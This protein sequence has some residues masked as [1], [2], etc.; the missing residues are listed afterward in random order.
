MNKN[1]LRSK[2]AYANDTYK[3]LGLFLKIS[4]QCVCNKVNEKRGAEFTQKEIEKIKIRY[5]LS[6]KEIDEIF[7]N[8][9]VS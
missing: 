9:K 4:E 1:A 5:Q 2:M 6:P 7:F 8:Q 3:S